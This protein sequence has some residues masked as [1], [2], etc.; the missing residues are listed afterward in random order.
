MKEADRDRMQ[1]ERKEY[2]RQ[3][4][5]NQ[6][7]SRQIQ[8]LQQQLSVARS[9]QQPPPAPTDNISV[10][11]ASQISQVTKGSRYPHS[12]MFGGRN[13]QANNRQRPP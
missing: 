3:K 4:G 10:G 13:E 9:V 12:T 5:Q 11:Y 1:R 6:D 8:E 2:N 7:Q